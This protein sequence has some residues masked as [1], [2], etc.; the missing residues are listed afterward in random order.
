MY[1]SR[2]LF[3]PLALV[4]STGAVSLLFHRLPALRPA[5]PSRIANAVQRHLRRHPLSDFASGLKKMRPSS[6]RIRDDVAVWERGTSSKDGARRRRGSALTATR[7]RAAAGTSATAASRHF[8]RLRTRRPTLRSRRRPKASSHLD[9][10]AANKQSPGTAWGPSDVGEIFL[11]GHLREASGNSQCSKIHLNPG[12]DIRWVVLFVERKLAGQS[13]RG[14]TP[15]MDACAATEPVAFAHCFPRL[16]P[17]GSAARDPRR[18]FLPSTLLS[19]STYS[20]VT[21]RWSTAHLACRD[22]A[23]LLMN[24]GSPKRHRRETP[25]PPPTHGRAPLSTN[26]PP[27]S[28]DEQAAGLPPKSRA[29]VGSVPKSEL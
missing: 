12:R 15:Y 8:S 11:R 21:E 25:F 19:Q 14:H 28:A 17:F 23:I 2:L 20:R 5:S 1:L 6:C 27:P 9:L 3:Q 16:T 22:P 29:P 7:R 18:S 26:S 10:R 13:T 24:S 4:E